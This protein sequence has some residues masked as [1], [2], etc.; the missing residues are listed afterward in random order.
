[1]FHAGKRHEPV[2]AGA[3]RFRG[4]PGLARL[5]LVAVMPWPF[6]AG[7]GFW[8]DFRSRDYSIKS[9]FVHE[10]PLVVLGD[11]T[12][13]G[14]KRARAL[15]SLREPKQNGGTDQEQDVVVKVLVS[16]ATND[17]EAWCRIRAIESLGAFKDLRAIRGL[18]DAYY[19]ADAFVPE[20]R[21]DLRQHV[22]AA[23]GQTSNP[24]AINLLV[25]VLQEPPPEAATTSAQDQQYYLD[26]RIAA[27]TALQNFK[28]YRA[29]EALALVLKSD[30]DTAL[31]NEAHHSLE[32][33][34]GKKLP[35][36]FKAWDDLLHPAEN[37][38]RDA[39]AKEKKATIGP[40]I[41][42]T[43]GRGNTPAP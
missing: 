13:D 24:E 6:L 11:K 19:K 29:T 42:Q 14:N 34:T 10:D 40:P 38:N 1:V 27:A 20:T 9:F 4:C 41:I 25:N 5:L 15:G 37:P 12:S 23:M 43:G 7:C 32:V 36:E 30:K 2:H 21:R 18:E 31:R 26:G 39:V 17:P 22:L 16:A 33:A 8:D 28:Q 3:T 35:A